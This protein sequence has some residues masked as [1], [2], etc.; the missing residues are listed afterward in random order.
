MS[1]CASSGAE[2]VAYGPGLIDRVRALAPDGID[3]ALDTAGTDEA[4]DTSIELVADRNRIATIVAF[5][6]GLE[7]GLKVLGGGP[8]ADPGT[9]VRDA[10]RLELV[11]LIDEGALQVFVGETFALTDAAGAHETIAAGRAGGKLILVP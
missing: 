4:I 5:G 9:E 2:P 11:R 7:L 10:A 8:G 6:R 3:V 1:S